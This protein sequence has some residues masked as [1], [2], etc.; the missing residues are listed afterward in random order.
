[1]LLAQKENLL[2]YPVSQGDRGMARIF[3]R[4]MG[5]G[6]PGA[7]VWVLTRLSCHFHHRL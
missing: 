5:V 3:Q 7:K 1:M 2:E 6:G 4:E